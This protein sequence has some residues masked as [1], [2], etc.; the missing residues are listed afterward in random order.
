M[1]RL[2]IDRRETKAFK[3]QNKRFAKPP[4]H[5]FVYSTNFPNRFG[6]IFNK[7][8]HWI[9]AAVLFYSISSTATFCAYEMRALHPI[10]FVKKIKINRNC[11]VGCTASERGKKTAHNTAN[12]HINLVAL[13]LLLF[14]DIIACTIATTWQE[15]LAFSAMRTFSHC[16]SALRTQTATWKLFFINIFIDFVGW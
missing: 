16:L 9:L 14:L 1:K 13:L 12:N 8:V 10:I 5:W 4:Q 7:L 15:F 11:F 6:I 3:M 2:L